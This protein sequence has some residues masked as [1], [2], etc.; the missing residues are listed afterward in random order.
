MTHHHVDRPT[1]YAPAVWRRIAEAEGLPD[2]Q[3]AAEYVDRAH[4]DN[5]ADAAL[6]AELAALAA[7]LLTSYLSAPTALPPFGDSSRRRAVNARPWPMPA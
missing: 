4:L 2:A 1:V 5:A 6:R 3:F 7:R